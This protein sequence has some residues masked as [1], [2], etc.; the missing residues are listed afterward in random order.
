VKKV[1]N[2][3]ITHPE[4]ELQIGE[5]KFPTKG[6]GGLLGLE[7][8]RNIGLPIDHL[9]LVLTNREYKFEKHSPVK[10]KLG[11]DGKLNQVFSGSLDTIEAEISKVSINA[12]GQSKGLVDLRVNKLYQDQSAGSI[13]KDLLSEAKVE[14]H[15][16]QDG[17]SFPLYV[18]DER[19]NGLEHIIKLGDR[20]GYDVYTTEEG[21]LAFKRFETKKKS[22]LKFSVDVL[23]VEM[24]KRERFFESSTIYGESPSSSKGAET[25]HWWTKEDIKATAGEGKAF[26]LNDPA[27]RSSENAEKVSKT[28]QEWVSYNQYLAVT[29]IGKPDIQIGHTV[30]LEGFSFPT[31]NN[32]YEVIGVEHYMSK[33]RGFTSRFACRRRGKP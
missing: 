25:F 3:T 2:M 33:P 30:I 9:F 22:K 12:I 28:M 21:K 31:M 5:E 29:T 14:K 13:V 17:I 27:I 32:D 26:V 4:F 8:G 1:R 6:D 7:M 20:C 15:E 16:I 18:V 19:H 10:L 11:Y 24:K 23:G